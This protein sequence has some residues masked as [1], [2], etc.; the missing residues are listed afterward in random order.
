MLMKQSDLGA[1]RHSGSLV[2]RIG[3]P[4]IFIYSVFLMDN[5]PLIPE[6]DEAIPLPESATDAL[7]HLTPQEELEMRARTIQMVNELLGSSTEATDAEKKES[8][9]LA[10]QM[11]LD[12]TARPDFSKYPN[13]VIQELAESF[14]QMNHV[15]VK[16]YADIKNYIVNKLMIEA[17]ASKDGRIRIAAL[18]KLGE[19]DGVDAFKKRTE[20]TITIKPIE[21]VENELRGVIKAL[22]ARAIEGEYVEIKQ[23][24]TTEH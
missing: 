15:V 1:Y 4:Y 14:R 9:K 18:T 5:T 10:M 8:R 19:V 22:K 7:P 21:E 24:K 17:E 16:D 2:R 12:P 3:L 23:E 13:V 20:T 6:I 11:S